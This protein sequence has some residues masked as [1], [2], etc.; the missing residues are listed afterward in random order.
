MKPSRFLLL[1]AFGLSIA[2]AQV[3]MEPENKPVTLTGTIRLLQGYGPP[4]WG[5]NK[6]TDPKFTYLVIELSNPINT[7]CT[8][9]RPEWKS[10][11]CSSAKQLE[12]FFDSS[13]ADGLEASAKKLV[14]RRATVAGTLQRAIAPT[15]MTP[16]YIEVTAIQ[17]AKSEIGSNL[18]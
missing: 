2:H 8:P 11:E 16:I 5:E 3:T 17:A 9:S 15:E 14:G 18:R 7:P 4:G 6:K 1:F 10:A 12:L 13:T